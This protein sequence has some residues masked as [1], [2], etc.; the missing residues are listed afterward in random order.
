[1]CGKCIQFDAKIEHYERLASAVT[2]QLTLDRFK[3]A[4]TQIRAEKAAMHPGE[5]SKR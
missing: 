5:S 2:D 1:M 4:I 3:E